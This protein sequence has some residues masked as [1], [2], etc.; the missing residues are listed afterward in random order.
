M[1]TNIY[2]K[3]VCPDFSTGD[4]ITLNQM[5]K[6]SLNGS[7]TDLAKQEQI[8]ETKLVVSGEEKGRL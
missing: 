1:K 8:V 6:P 5:V 4:S 2:P 3:T 7:R